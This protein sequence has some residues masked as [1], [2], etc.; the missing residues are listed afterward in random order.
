MIRLSLLPFIAGVVSHDAEYWKSFS[1]YSLLCGL[2]VRIVIVLVEGSC[3]YGS[4]LSTSVRGG[5]FL[6]NLSN[7]QLFGIVLYGITDVAYCGM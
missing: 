4:E 7:R 2:D 1:S 3:M 6:H 5:K